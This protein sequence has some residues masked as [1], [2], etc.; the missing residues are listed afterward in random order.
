MDA[1]L[2]A[3]ASDPA[4][5]R[6]LEDQRA[7]RSDAARAACEAALRTRPADPRALLV[8][9][10]VA[11]EAGDLERA[12][13]LLQRL[14]TVAPGDAAGHYLLGKAYRALGR[15]PEALGCF[16]EAARLA[17]DHVDARFSMAV[18]HCER[19]AWREAIPALREVLRLRP[20][21]PEA[22]S[23]LGTALQ[24]RG[25][26]DEAVRCFQAAIRLRPDYHEA[27]YNLGNAYKEMGDLGHAA[28]AYREA[29]RLAPGFAAAH[30]NLGGVFQG[31]GELDQAEAAYTSALRANPQYEMALNGLGLVRS[32]RGYI[33]EAIGHY[34]RALALKPDFAEA[35]LNLGLALLL[36][37]RL[38]E[39]WQEY[40]WR[41]RSPS[42]RREQ[43]HTDRPR[44]AGEP[45]TGRTILLH[46]E[47]G[48]GDTIQFARLAPD[49]AA[50]GARVLLEVDEPLVD[51]FRASF[52]GIEV[53]RRGERL[54]PFDCQCPLLSLPRILG[55][56][57]DNVPAG[58]PYLFADDAR[59]SAWE[60]RLGGPPARRV[61]LAWAGSPT[62]RYDRNRTIPAAVLRP[63][64]GVARARFY[65][66]QKGPAATA[67][68]ALG[69]GVAD[70]TGELASFADTAALVACL[71][72]VVT[73]DT[74]V[75]HLAGALGKPV[76][77]LTPFAPD[78][79]WLLE[80][81]D[82]P[83]YPTM[84]LF[85]QRRPDDWGH[86]V[87]EACT[88][89]AAFC[90]GTAAPAGHAGASGE[91]ARRKRA[92]AGR[93]TD[94]ARWSDPRQLEPMWERRAALA[95]DH[96]PA[97]AAV[98]DLGCGAM[99]L[100]RHLPFGCGYLPVDVV[101]RDARTRVC[102]F[103]RDPLPPAAGAAAVAVLG[104][105]EY[106]FDVDAFLRQLG[107]YRLPVVLSYC[108]ADFAPGLDRESL[109]W[110]NRLTR[111]DL[112]D[113]L[114][115]AGL[116]VRAE[117]RIDDLQ[118]LLALQ[119]RARTAARSPRVAVLSYNNVG[120]FG[121]RLGYHLVNEVIPPHATV[122]HAH[123]RPWDLPAEAFDLLIVGA[124]NSL[125]APLLGDELVAALERA[126]AAI[127]VF[128]TQYREEIDP[129]AL[130]RVLDRLGTWYARSEED[131]LLY[132]KGRA[133]ARH[134]GDWLISAFPLANG[135]DARV[136]DVADEIWQDLP[137][138]R[139]IQRIQAHR[140]VR[141]RRLHPLLC[142]LASA[143]AVAYVEQRETPRRVPSGK[144][145]S[146]L[147][148]V[149]GRTYP[150]E[151]FFE[152]DRAAVIDYRRDVRSRMDELRAALASVLGEPPPP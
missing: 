130:A 120:N 144:F 25:A 122:T 111:R 123:F 17:P 65:S 32:E 119:P 88:A 75:A 109:G 52:A 58:I 34:R 128:G 148:D 24:E 103:N 19:A 83:W 63:L 82:S 81:A 113:A 20:D 22:Y 66:L 62:H 146:A 64:T 60:T 10:I 73:A 56:T 110:V 152:V 6:A 27:H 98:L 37:G 137:L 43:R 53:L 33:E 67:V 47:Q 112:L 36:T 101:A 139:T 15:A 105:L 44:W 129:R 30:G 106:V 107:A 138:D 85:R 72:L 41:W 77:L 40:E 5:A 95:A 145:R 9:G 117:R 89:L 13:G 90:G 104:V 48:L 99:T 28:E 74:A 29:I 115:D 91:A 135:A 54:P 57:L 126:R 51:L 133:N 124:G 42:L 70:W 143:E 61:G 4:L 134:L 114:R 8:A 35:H 2:A 18:L 79:R 7:G 23:N 92:I 127:G 38:G 76:W 140:R 46:A 150:E 68:Q 21:Y 12:V 87:G 108:P 1:L 11:L 121:D 31:R 132:G 26:F 102:D 55:I 94:L 149:F 142:A 151:A 71:D 80:R 97:G 84:R 136:L 50:R 69:P 141:S 118:L 116:H 96:L 16:E 3:A 59:R 131:L 49:V 14:T 78:W 100:E 93:T 147:I 125:F 86:V 39:G 45:L